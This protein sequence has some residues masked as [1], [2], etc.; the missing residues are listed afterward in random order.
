LAQETL[1]DSRATSETRALY[2]HLAALA[3]S[4]LIIGQQNL[5]REGHGWQWQGTP[6]FEAVSG[7]LPGVMGIDFREV[8]EGG[9]KAWKH[10]SESVQKFHKKGGIVTLSWHM[11]NPVSDK[12]F[13]DKTP[14]VSKI[15][16]GKALHQ[17]YK[18]WLDLLAKFLFEQKDESGN[19]IPILFRPFHEHN[20]NW[21][22]WSVTDS[23]CQQFC[24]LG[25]I[26]D[27]YVQKANQEF[28]ALWRFTID[29]LVRQR[30]LH[31][32]II[33]YSPGILSDSS[34]GLLYR[35]PGDGY[36]DILAYDKYGPSLTPY[37]GALRDLVIQARHRKK[38][39][40]LAETGYEGIP[41]PLYFTDQVLDVL[42]N[43]ALAKQLAYVMFWKNSGRSGQEGHYFLPY[44]GH[45]SRPNFLQM[46][47][48]PFILT[49]DWKSK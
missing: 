1:R 46:L 43:D 14:A 42:K 19:L 27:S 39:A 36:V 34:K 35:Y 22:W 49:I 10:Y 23:V 29:Y 3:P 32:L 21:F 6:D 26:N 20:G 45:A 31:N 25:F 12:N 41:N 5:Y 4:H 15:L 38:L 11:Q 7:K 2:H 13:F 8:H 24:F 18:D 16:P 47:S 37:L 44:L 33:V 17:K 48:D 9:E 28:I 40:A 30:G